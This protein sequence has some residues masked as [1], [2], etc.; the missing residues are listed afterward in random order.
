MQ[1]WIMQYWLGIAFS[2][3]IGAFGFGCRYIVKTLKRDYIEPCA[4]NTSRINS[5]EEITV[6]ILN[7]DRAQIRSTLNHLMNECLSKGF[8]TDAEYEI[9][10]DLLERYEDCDGNG[11]MHKKWERF[12]Q[13]PI[14]NDETCS[15]RE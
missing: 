13:L 5:L 11:Y 4:Q 14:V 10:I 8:C 1:E 2:G 7:N 15:L 12:D 9:A 3:M 6:K